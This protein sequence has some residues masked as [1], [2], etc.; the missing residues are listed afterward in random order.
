MIYSFYSDTSLA[1]NRFCSLSL[2]GVPAV[3]A[4]YLLHS[5]NPRP[6]FHSL[7]PQ[8]GIAKT[9]QPVI[10]SDISLA[11]DKHVASNVEHCIQTLERAIAA[12]P[13]GV[14]SY[15]WVSD[16]HGFSIYDCDPRMAK[17]C[18]QVRVCLGRGNSAYGATLIPSIRPQWPTRF[19]VLRICL[20]SPACGI[21]SP[22]FVQAVVP[23]CPYERID[24]IA[25]V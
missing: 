13:D 20:L 21:R 9:G 19:K 17:G 1:R 7:T 10:Y 5:F 3:H 14:E 23:A 11:R 24:P 15:I 2:S 22:S 16:F 4:H 12:M 6:L 25:C 18:L 8:V